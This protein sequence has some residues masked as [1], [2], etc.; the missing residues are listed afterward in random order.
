[1][2]R[3]KFVESPTDAKDNE[4]K[5]LPFDFSELVAQGFMLRKSETGG[6]LK[7]KAVIAYVDGIEIGS[8]TVSDLNDGEL[9]LVCQTFPE[10]SFPATIRFSNIENSVEIAPPFVL[11]RREQVINLLGYK[12]LEQVELFIE[13]GI[14]KG[15]AS[16]SG[17]TLQVP[18]L[19]CRVNGTLYREVSMEALVP[20]A[21]GGTHVRFSVRIDPADLHESGSHFEILTLPRLDLVGSK[22][23]APR[24]VRDEALETVTRIATEVDQVG[25]RLDY[26]ISIREAR[27]KEQNKVNLEFIDRLG[28]YLLSVV[29]DQLN[30]SDK[31]EI[32]TKANTAI[33]GFRDLID[34]AA[35]VDFKLTQPRKF[36]LQSDAA[37]FVAGW[38]DH[39]LSGD[40]LAFR[41]MTQRGSV[42]NPHP[43]LDVDEVVVNCLAS[44]SPDVLPVQAFLDGRPAECETVLQDEERPFLLRIKPP[45]NLPF[46]RLDLVA[47]AAFSP[48][49]MHQGNDV[50]RLSLA[51]NAVVINYTQSK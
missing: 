9:L 24:W 38:H 21:S 1:M 42:H 7:T 19:I 23:V 51:V 12:P 11:E 45:D 4:R 10:T 5:P 50:R 47:S 3:D 13:N 44:I 33:S 39:E 17:P 8:A 30:A 32:S 41:W 25:K 49:D 27:R 20:T 6:D 36:V 46:Y 15:A 14:I 48:K 29:F 28:Q 34:Q 40:K 2:S 16:I 37:G 31:P 35:D 26:E 43:D 22:Q 18:A